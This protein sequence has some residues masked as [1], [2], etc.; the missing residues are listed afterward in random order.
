MTKYVLLS[1]NPQMSCEVVQSR[2]V[3]QELVLDH[4]T[5]V[6][7]THDKVSETMGSKRLHK[8]RQTPM[9]AMLIPCRSYA[10]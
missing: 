7:S 8:E 5:S 4:V 3:I 1:Q 2:A 10:R 6:P 9:A